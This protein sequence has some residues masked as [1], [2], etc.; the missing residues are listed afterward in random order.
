M[1]YWIVYCISM[2][3]YNNDSNSEQISFWNTSLHPF[4]SLLSFLLKCSYRIKWWNYRKKYT[5]WSKAIGWWVFEDL[6]KISIQQ[7]SW[8]I[9]V[10]Y[11]LAKQHW[12][13]SM[14]VI[15]EYRRF[16]CITGLTYHE[17]NLNTILF[18]LLRQKTLLESRKGMQI[19]LV[20]TVRPRSLPHL[21]G[22]DV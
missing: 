21:S 17:R 20:W 13:I 4:P 18:F 7:E 10:H 16:S 14:W 2:S 12:F 3:E 5:K 11:I 1:M 6:N 9:Q 8:D 19:T 15:K 22:L